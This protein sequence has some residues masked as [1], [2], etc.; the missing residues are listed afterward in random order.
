MKQI[1]DL[2]NKWF[3]PT[4]HTDIEHYV[5]SKNPTTPAEVDYW[6]RQYDFQRSR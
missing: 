6:I 5:I 3:S 2:L 1:I 4:L